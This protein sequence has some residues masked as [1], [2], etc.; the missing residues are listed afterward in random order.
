MANDCILL[1][2][3][4]IAPA[5]G[6][7]TFTAFEPATGTE[8][9]AAFPVTGSDQLDAMLAAGAT[10]AVELAAIDPERIAAFLGAFATAIE[11]RAD[12]LVAM[13]ARETALPAEPRLRNVE[14][15]RT[16][17]QLRQAAAAA[18]EGSWSQP[19]IDSKLNIRSR[20]EPLGKPVVVI[21]PNNFPFA[22]NAISGGDCAAAIAAG[23]PVI[24][25]AHTAHPGTS[26]LLA[27]AAL[28]AITS[29]GMPK[30]TVQ[31]FYHCAP[32]DG[33]RLV[34]DHRVGA[35]AFTG[36]KPSGLKLKAAA[37][38]AGVPIYLELG[39]I[40]PVFVLPGALRE[41]GEALATEFAGSC[42]LGTGQFCTNPGL[43]L[44]VKSA[45]A[46]AF[47]AAVVAKFKAA[48]AGALF[49]A[50]MAGKLA[51]ASEAMVKAGA[52]VECGGA[53]AQGA[54][55]RFANTV[56]SV[57]GGT[58]LRHRA[59]LQQE[60]FGPSTMVVVADDAEQLAALVT[61]LEPSLT[62]SIYS[63][64]DG[65]DDSL[66]DRIAPALAQK[67]G[68]LLNDKMPTGVAVSPAMVHGGPFPASGHPGFTA[69]GI[70]ASIRRFGALRCYD[71]VRA[72]RLP[73]IL[74]DANPRGHAW[75]CV[76]GE[77]TK[78]D[79]SARGT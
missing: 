72:A 27:E 1:S 25:K 15:P 41:K 62:G 26:R 9:P 71:N 10:A 48:P 73:G 66:H 38:A 65:A 52:K 69:V 55:F 23:N 11:T 46:N 68:R 47:V 53:P 8:I 28:E 76:D 56:F 33:L 63:A 6:Q 74:R 70:P 18:R 49:A 39:S 16:T 22:F 32:A 2:G 21:G 64:Q 14:L 36:G 75:R 5:A 4:W 40:N 67:V 31:M 29:T 50:G 54:G 35:V 20:F 17:G 3:E 78:A 77:W 37:D 43:V 42:L 13:A 30:A 24:A 19:T 60:M 79:V 34:A 61:L 58:F 44:T 59:I 51:A 7:E 45:E 12:A 57:S